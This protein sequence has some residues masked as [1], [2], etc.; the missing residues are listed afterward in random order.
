MFSAVIT[1][2]Q[3]I[4]SALD[5]DRFRRVID[6]HQL[7]SFPRFSPR[8][9]PGRSGLFAKPS[10]RATAQRSPWG[11][12]TSPDPQG[13]RRAL[14][15]LMATVTLTVSC[16][17]SR[18]RS[19]AAFVCPG[20]NSPLSV[21]PHLAAPRPVSNAHLAKDVC[22]GVRGTASS[23]RAPAASPVSPAMKPHD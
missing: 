15:L 9:R 12:G 16:A 1:L 19:S 5:G 22:R 8:S 18:S 6:I 4:K 7:L 21:P 20:N 17:Q 11:S 10:A 3:V 2:D 23:C 14:S 13:D